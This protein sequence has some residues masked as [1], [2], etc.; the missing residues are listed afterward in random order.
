LFVFSAGCSVTGRRYQPRTVAH[1]S[2]L[3][4]ACS[5]AAAAGKTPGKVEQAASGLSPVDDHRAYQ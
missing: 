2:E 5:L 4:S 3:P 1:V